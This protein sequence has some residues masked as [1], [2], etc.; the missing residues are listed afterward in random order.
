M[1]T[2]YKKVHA[3]IRADPSVAKSTKESPK[4]H[5]RYEADHM[6]QSVSF[7]ANLYD[8][9]LRSLLSYMMQVQL[10][11]AYACGEEIRAC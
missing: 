5:K 6:K 3:A 11:E 4:E 1:E 8:L 2:L 10:E 9:S 7:R